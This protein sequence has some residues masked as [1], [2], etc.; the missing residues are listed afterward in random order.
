MPY[1]APQTEPPRYIYI[2]TSN[3][4]PPFVT[5]LGRMVKAGQHASDATEACSA[6]GGDKPTPGRLGEAWRIGGRGGH[7]EAGEEGEAGEAGDRHEEAPGGQPAEAQG[8]AGPATAAEAAAEAAG[9]GGGQCAARK[10]LQGRGVV[11]W[12]K[13]GSV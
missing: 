11:G 8:Q 13:R 3:T 10:A 9:S 5:D 4:R 1:I 2:Y 7:R 6:G 12:E